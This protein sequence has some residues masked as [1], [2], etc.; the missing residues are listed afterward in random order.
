MKFQ[1]FDTEDTEGHRV[2]L[3]RSDFEHAF[4]FL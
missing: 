1:V 2:N 3:R 4:I